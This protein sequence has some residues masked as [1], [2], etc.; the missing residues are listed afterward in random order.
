MSRT[1]KGYL[2]GIIGTAF[3]SSA[4]V[5]MSY[6]TGTH[7][8][9]PLLLALWRDL[10]VCLILIPVLYAWRHTLLHMD[11]AH[12]KLFAL[13]GLVLSVFN[14]IWTISCQFNGASVATVLVY[15]SAG[16]TALLAWR[17]FGEKLG[18]A[19]LLAVAVSLGGCVLV[20]NAYDAEMWRLNA[21]GITTGLLSGLMFAIYSLMGKE[22]ARRGI[23]S[24]SALLFSFGSAVFFLLLFNIALLY[25]PF[26]PPPPLG[27]GVSS[28]IP[29]LAPE[30]WLAMI[31]LALVPTIV[32]Y[33]LYIVEM[34]YL[35]AGTANL[36][37]TLEPFFTSAQAFVLLGER[38]TVVQVGGG[39]LIVAA[40]VLVRLAEGRGNGPGGS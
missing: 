34:G 19:R 26:I 32:G 24:W 28:L 36:I 14:S 37:A 17:L 39:L 12:W 30:G 4:A 25:M 5:F 35:P 29:S 16:F 21:A 1:T 15:G 7:H 20:A 38:M 6:L 23:N 31:A 2:I 40:V 3:W 11:R 13:Y 18:L 22:T 10:I 9:P 33:G 27:V 8:M